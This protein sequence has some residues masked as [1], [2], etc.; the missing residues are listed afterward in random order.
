MSR[1]GD[2]DG[3]WLGEVF[4]AGSVHH[5]LARAKAIKRAGS[6]LLSNFRSHA[7]LPRHVTKLTLRVLI[8]KLQ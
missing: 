3:A 8:G 7:G 6:R 1:S 4:Q 5:R 2:G